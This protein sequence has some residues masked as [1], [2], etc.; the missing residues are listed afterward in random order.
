MRTREGERSSTCMGTD[1]E[2]MS[3][4]YSPAYGP[5][6]ITCS[7]TGIGISASSPG[8]YSV[9]VPAGATFETVVDEVNTAAKPGGVNVTW[10]SD[11]PWA[12]ARPFPSGLAAVGQTLTTSFDVWAR[13]WP[14][15]VS[16]SGATP[17]AGA[18]SISRAPPARTMCRPTTTSAT[19][20]AWTRAQ[21]RRAPL[22]PARC[23]DALRPRRSSSRP[24]STRVSRS[25]RATPHSPGTWPSWPPKQLPG[26]EVR[27]GDDRRRDPLHDVFMVRSLINEPACV[28]VARDPA[29]KRRDLLSGLVIYS[30]TFD[31]ADL[32]TNYVADDSTLDARPP[33]AR[34]SRRP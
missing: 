9:V 2:V 25:S 32:T 24:W 4:T 11:R 22:D 28:W 17:P 21:R 3:E 8:S 5:A 16:G 31:P 1:G 29:R 18:A 10:S 27:A 30:P 14:S 26:A 15:A 19:S 13:T 33:R 6:S 23:T 7:P 12:G 20:F 34:H